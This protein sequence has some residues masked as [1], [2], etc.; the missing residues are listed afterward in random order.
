MKKIG[1]LPYLPWYADRKADKQWME[2]FGCGFIMEE[3]PEERRLHLGLDKLLESIGKGDTLL[4]SK[5]AHIVNGVRQLSYFLDFCKLK[6]VRLVSLH[7]G[8]DSHDELFPETKVSDLL[9]FIAG[10]PEEVNAVRKSAIQSGRRT[11]GIKVLSQ[12]AYGRAERNKLV[13][14][15]Y[16]S[17]YTIDDIWKTSGFRSR[18]SVF[19]V[20]KDEGVELKRIRGRASNR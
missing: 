15:M 10:L 13:V 12:V 18:S 19:R 17:G 6:G 14:N 20:L 4:I 11:K 7:D 9:A 8:I 5:L 1:Y 3:Q 2:D 16:R